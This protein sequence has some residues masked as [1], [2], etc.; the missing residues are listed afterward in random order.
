MKRVLAG[1]T[2]LVALV[3]V[4]YVV[5]AITPRSQPSVFAVAPPSPTPGLQVSPVPFS[6]PTPT[7]VP[8]AAPTPM[9]TPSAKVSPVVTPTPSPSSVV[10]PTIAPTSSPWTSLG[11]AGG[12]VIFRRCDGSVTVYVAIISSTVTISTIGGGCT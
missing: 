5:L 12:A 10:P 3:I 4:G 8:T 11:S 1:T 6:S 2:T 9:V 7:V